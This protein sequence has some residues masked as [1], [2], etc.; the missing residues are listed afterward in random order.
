MGWLLVMA[1]FD[2]QQASATSSPRAAGLRFDRTLNAFQN[3]WLAT[4]SPVRPSLART[5]SVSGSR[6]QSRPRQ[7]A[8]RRS[9]LALADRAG[10][11]DL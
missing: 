7:T 3:V 8:A 10:A 11:G 4:G 2:I 9:G 1:L 6:D 5:V